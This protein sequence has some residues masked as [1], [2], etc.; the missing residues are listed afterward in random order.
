MIGV[1]SSNAPARALLQVLPSRLIAGISRRV[2][3]NYAGINEGEV[4]ISQRRNTP[5]KWTQVAVPVRLGTEWQDDFKLMVKLFPMKRRTLRTKGDRGAVNSQ[6]HVWHSL[7]ELY[8]GR[9]G[10]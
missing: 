8:A 4:T 10:S 2:W 3:Q 7:A 1:F 5:R 9:I 6:A